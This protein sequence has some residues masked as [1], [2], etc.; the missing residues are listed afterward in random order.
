MSSLLTL[1]LKDKKVLHE[2]WAPEPIMALDTNHISGARE[3]QIRKEI[4]D[5]M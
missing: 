5:Y 2:S 3:E 1:L 4:S